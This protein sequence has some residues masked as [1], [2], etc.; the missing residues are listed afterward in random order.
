MK[1]R[2]E[3]MAELPKFGTKEST[4][5]HRAYYAQ[6]VLPHVRRLVADR[7]GVHVIERS[8][9]KHLNDIPLHLWDSIWRRDDSR[10][11]WIEPGAMVSGLLKA[12]GEGNS[13]STG[14]CVLKEAARQIKEARQSAKERTAR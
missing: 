8:S 11:M 6:F 5:A 3:Y 13:A 10:G 14:V 1:T 12:A 9:D 4:A 2:Q 7:I